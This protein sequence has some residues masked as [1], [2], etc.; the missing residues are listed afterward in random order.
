[1]S[2][3]DNP[4]WWALA[5]PQRGPGHGHAAGRP[6]PSRVSPFG[7]FADVPTTDHWRIMADLV[8]PGERWPSPVTDVP[9]PTGWT[10]SWRCPESRW[11]ASRPDRGRAT[12]PAPPGGPTG[13]DVPVPLGARRRCR[14]AGAGGGGQAGPVP[15]PAPSSSVATSA[16]DERAGWWPWP[17]SGCAS[18]VT[19]RSARWPPIPTTAP[20]PGE[21][22]VRSVVSPALS[23]EGAVP[24][25][26]AASDQCGCHP[27][28]RA[29]GIH[30]SVEPLSFLVVQAPASLIVRRLVRWR[31]SI[32]P[33]RTRSTGRGPP[34]AITTAEGWLPTSTRLTDR[35][36]GQVHVDQRRRCH[37]TPTPWLRPGPAPGPRRWCRR[38]SAAPACQCGQVDRGHAVTT[39]HV[40]RCRCRR[41]GDVRWGCRPP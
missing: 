35:A 7:A 17:A 19:S 11:S 27:S 6:V 15:V 34:A 3:L 12:G 21:L 37:R 40:D 2:E 29:T 36:V 9:P 10:V 5:G 18:R 24:F 41:P 4:V 20:G 14:H 13:T 8:G 33:E 32:R 30:R 22:L 25:L 28:L 16:S 1:M 31:P 23:E 26:H 39:A 38:R